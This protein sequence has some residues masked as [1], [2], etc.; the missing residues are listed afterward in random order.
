MDWLSS[1]AWIWDRHRYAAAKCHRA[2]SVESEGCPNR[3]GFDLLHS[4]LGGA[5]ATSVANNIFTN[6]L[7]QGLARIP[8]VDIGTVAN[9]GATD[10][11]HFVPPSTLPQVLTVYNKALVHAF[12]VGVAFSS[13]AIF[14]T[15]PMQWKS[16][17]KSEN[18]SKSQAKGSSVMMPKTPVTK[19]V[20]E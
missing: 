11:R 5:I 17:R 3:D 10:L 7:A 15:L 4:S 14:G 19:D 9:V 13:L 12:D 1:S 18:S 2:D 6:K 20:G 16:I 8:G